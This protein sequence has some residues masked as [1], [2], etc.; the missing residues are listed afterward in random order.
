MSRSDEKERQEKELASILDAALDDLDD[1]E[2]ED[3]PCITGTSD[4]VALPSHDDVSDT[5]V[6]EKKPPEPT[7]KKVAGP[8]PP[9]PRNPQDMTEEDLA[10]SLDDMMKNLMQLG[11]GPDGGDFSSD[12]TM[13]MFFQQMMQGEA[14]PSAMGSGPSSSSSA[15]KKKKEG[16]ASEK[17][18]TS[19]SKTKSKSPKKQG[20][21]VDRTVEKILEDMSKHGESGV[22]DIPDMDMLNDGMM[23]S[24]MKEFEK[25][26]Q[27][28][29]GT[30]DMINGMMKQLLCKDLMYEPMQ[31]VTKKFPIWLADAK[32]RLSQEDYN[33]YGQQ[34]QYFQQIVHVYETEPDN[35]P[36]LMELM[37][38]IQDY[39]QPP[40]EIMKE[41]APGL[42]MDEDGMPKMDMPFP[43]NEQCCIM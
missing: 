38:E 2:D 11:D 1:E 9:P 24:M 22:D 41:L 31:Q 15:K 6:K 5:P 32:P 3:E 17:P 33:R 29:G 21:D 42:E 43:G 14:A 34:Y 36:R 37:Q 28:E 23:D 30:D 20:S 27:Q 8:P 16:T 7:K 26:G 13:N 10:A 35:F 19:S 4:N 40:A 25:M 12:Q 18:K 39:G